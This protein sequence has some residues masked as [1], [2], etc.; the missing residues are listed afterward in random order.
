MSLGKFDPNKR[1][2]AEL[3]DETEP[4]FFAW[5]VGVEKDWDMIDEYEKDLLENYLFKTFDRVSLDRSNKI[6]KCVKDGI[7]FSLEHDSSLHKLDLRI[8]E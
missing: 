3:L 5:T 8:D 6:A 2:V 7:V 1:S 4:F